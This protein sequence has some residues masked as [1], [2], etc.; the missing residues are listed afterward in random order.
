MSHPGSK[1]WLY[2]SRLEHYCEFL[3]GYMRQGY[4]REQAKAKCSEEKQLYGSDWDAVVAAE[5][6]SYNRSQRGGS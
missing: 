2:E 4:T 1:R 5:E 3:S 6:K